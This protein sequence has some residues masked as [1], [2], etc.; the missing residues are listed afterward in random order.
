[1]DC[2]QTDV[3][4]EG[5]LSLIQPLMIPGKFQTT[6]TTSRVKY[7]TLGLLFSLSLSLSIAPLRQTASLQFLT[8]SAYDPNLSRKPVQMNISFII[9]NRRFMF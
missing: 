7:P 1:M 3:R 4:I 6:R 2:I 8:R 9:L 5:S